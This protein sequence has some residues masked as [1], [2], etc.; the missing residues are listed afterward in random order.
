MPIPP[1]YQFQLNTPKQQ[2]ERPY[3]VEI[4]A[5]AADIECAHR[6]GYDPKPLYKILT[7][8]LAKQTA[9]LRTQHKLRG[10]FSSHVLSDSTL[11]EPEE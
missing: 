2:S 10:G 9:A 7:E 1:E 3:Q 8:L 11:H 6:R 5:T 4:D